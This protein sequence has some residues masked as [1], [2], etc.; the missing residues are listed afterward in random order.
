MPDYSHLCGRIEDKEETERLLSLSSTPYMTPI[1]ASIIG[2]GKGKVSYNHKIIKYTLGYFPYIVQ[3]TD[4]C[5]SFGYA[6]SLNCLKVIRK[7]QGIYSSFGGMTSTEDI[8]GGSRVLIGKGQLGRR[9]GSVGIWAMEYG[10]KYGTLVR[11]KYDSIDLTTYSADRAISWGLSGPPKEL[12]PYAREHKVKI[13][14]QIKTWE[15]FRDALYNGYM[16]TVASNRGFGNRR[17]SEGYLTGK[18]TWPHQMYFCD[19]N[20][21]KRPGGLL[22]NSWP[23]DWVTGPRPDD[24]PEGTGWVDAEI[25]VRDMLSAGDTWV[26]SDFDDYPPQELDWNIADLALKKADN[27]V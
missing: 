12:L 2:S 18:A 11:K 23:K 8:Y 25:I 19:V 4:D 27:Y 21:T 6:G 3:E 17:D 15:E 20:D 16:I 10:Q 14:S 26:M 9:G 5:V 22:V 13:Y 7:F 24:I 1:C